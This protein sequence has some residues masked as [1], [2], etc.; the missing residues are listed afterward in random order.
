MDVKA[1]QAELAQFATERG[2]DAAQTPKNL[3]MALAIEATGVLELFKWQ[4]DEAGRATESARLRDSAADA[5]ADV[6]LQVLRLAYRLD[7]DVDRAVAV[8]LARNA[9]KYP[10][11]VTDELESDAEVVMLEAGVDQLPDET[12]DAAPVV[13]E[14]TPSPEP[15]A[16]ESVDAPGDETKPVEPSPPPNEPIKAEPAARVW[17]RDDDTAQDFRPQPIESRAP[18][19]AAT[20]PEPVVAPERRD[21]P[22]VPRAPERELS[23]LERPKRARIVQELSVPQR[24][25]AMPATKPAESAGSLESLGITPLALPTQPPAPQKEGATPVDPYPN[26]DLGDALALAKT[27][28]KKLDHARSRDPALR[29]LH[30]ELETLKRSLYAPSVKKAWVAG[31]LKAVRAILESATGE[32]FGEEIDAP[33]HLAKV[34]RLLRE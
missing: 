8:R 19:V 32:P 9:A 22:T 16:A 17:G 1:V 4:S 11:G 7:V 2:W 29:E 28:A 23:A 26:L 14:V 24:V 10:L 33:G 27:L 12:I 13:V 21:P 5:I 20:P 3:A 6:I 30:D 25:E 31:S 15:V 34:D 18:R